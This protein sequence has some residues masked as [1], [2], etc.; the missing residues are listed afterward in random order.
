MKKVYGY[1]RVSTETQADKGYGLD[2]QRQAIEKYCTDNSLELLNIFADEGITGTIGDNDDISKRQGLVDLL[3]TLNGT[4]TVVVMNTSRLWRDDGAKVFITREIRKLKGNIISIEQPKYSLYSKDPQDY[5]YNSLM[6]IL[7]QYDRLN[8]NMKLA[9]GRTTKAN[10]GDKP[11]GLTTFGYNY[12]VDKKSIVVDKK[13]ASIIKNIFNLYQSGK[14]IQDIADTLNKKGIK[15]R[16][17]CNW[18]KEGLRLI[19]RNKFYTGIVTHQ[20][21]EIKGNHEALISTEQFN[22][23]QDLLNTNNLH[24]AVEGSL[25]LN[26]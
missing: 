18:S 14:S 8:I 6:E 12:S 3:D 22:T 10:K 7:D 4:N 5:I 19:L 13:E 20:G 2:T 1:I 26:I 17:D 11:A 16:R 23:V 15:T 21:R 9:K 25:T 24:K